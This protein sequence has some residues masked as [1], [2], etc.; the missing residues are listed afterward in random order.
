MNI[1]KKLI[2]RYVIIP[3]LGIVMVGCSK[4]FEPAVSS[5]NELVNFSV[6]A[7]NSGTYADPN[8]PE[9]QLPNFVKDVQG[10]IYD[11]KIIVLA[12]YYA[13]T[14]K[15]L[16]PTFVHSDRAIAYIGDEVQDSGTSEVDFTNPVTYRVVSEDGQERSYSVEFY[17]EKPFLSYVVSIEENP[18][19]PYDSDVEIDSLNRVI[20]VVLR[21][22]VPLTDK[23]ARF[24]VPEEVSV[25]IAGTPQVSGESVIDLTNP[26]T[27]TLSLADD[28][29]ETWTV[30]ASLRDP[31]SEGDFLTFNFSKAKNPELM[32]DLVGE[33]NREN[34]S[35][36]VAS[37]WTAGMDNVPLTPDFT[38]S[39]YVKHVICIGVDQT[40]GHSVIDFS[41]T[42]T[43]TITSDDGSTQDWEVVFYKPTKFY[44]KDRYFRELLRSRH[45][46]LLEGD[47]LI[48]SKAI[49]NPL[50]GGTEWWG[51][52]LR[53][54]DLP[55]QDLSGIE[56]FQAI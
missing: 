38:T 36:R 22:G 46:D 16:K 30:N 54:P 39:K 53:N 35:I 5:R 32:G 15:G 19:L 21:R 2:N 51:D 49:D 40:S 8:D 3:L 41:T 23:I 28:Y 17:K 29:P 12:P 44:I 11:D 27:Y 45:P 26:V 20:N 37:Y 1:M 47:S 55:I 6:L 10:V 33:I 4:E 9:K 7:A 13:K 18:E 43:Y 24:V 56:Y 25:S 14:W 50:P 42:V 48:I 31:S 34:K 52:G